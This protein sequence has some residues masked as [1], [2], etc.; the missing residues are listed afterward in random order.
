M[1]I[2]FCFCIQRG[3]FLLILCG[4]T[5]TTSN[6]SAIIIS[7][8]ILSK[9]SLPLLLEKEESEFFSDTDKFSNTHGDTMTRSSITSHTKKTFLSLLQKKKMERR[10]THIIIFSLMIS[11]MIHSS[12]T[13]TYRK[14]E[15][16]RKIS[17]LPYESLLN[18]RNELVSR[19]RGSTVRFH[20]PVDFFTHTHIHMYREEDS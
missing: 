14:S 18:I 11:E 17:N 12:T 19:R 15:I 2:V 13:T 10:I 9:V 20:V 6:R 5:T 4:T 16:K 3:H 1:S 7:S 8:F